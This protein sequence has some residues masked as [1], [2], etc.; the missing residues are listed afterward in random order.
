MRDTSSWTVT[1]HNG[2]PYLEIE[3]SDRYPN[4]NWAPTA[5]LNFG[6]DW[7]DFPATIRKVRE[8]QLPD[9]FE[10]GGF[11]VGSDSITLGNGKI[12]RVS[13]KSA[14]GIGL[15]GYY[16]YITTPN[17]LSSIDELN[18]YPQLKQ[19]T[20]ISLSTYGN[21]SA[22]LF[23]IN[24]YDNK[25]TRVTYSDG[26]GWQS[27][28]NYT[29]SPIFNNPGTAIASISDEEGFVLSY[30]PVNSQVTLYHFKSAIW[31]QVV[32]PQRIKQHYFNCHWFDA[33]ALN[34]IDRLVVFNVNGMSYAMNV[35]VYGVM[36]SPWKIF[37]FDPEFGGAQVRICKLTK[38]NGR[39]IGT[40]WVRFSNS[41]NEYDVSYYQLV[42]TDDGI[43][44]SIPEEGFIGRNPV[45]GKVH[46]I[47]ST[48]AVLGATI[49]YTGKAVQWLGGNVGIITSIANNVINVSLAQDMDKASDAKISLLIP[50]DFNKDLLEY[51]NRVVIREGVVGQASK[52]DLSHLTLDT[53]G[54]KLDN[55]SQSIDAIARG[56]VKKLI[57]YTVPMDMTIEGPIN[58]YNDFTSGG[59]YARTGVW[60]SDTV[61]YCASHNGDWALGTIGLQYSG[62]FQ[63]NTSIRI[64]ES[65]SGSSG[66]I[67]FWYEGLLDYWIIDFINDS[68]ILKQVIGGTEVPITTS[69]ALGN[70]QANQWYDIIIRYI[71]GVLYVYVKTGDSPWELVISQSS[72]PSEEP[73]KW[74]TGLRCKLPST[75]ITESLSI[76]ET[77]IINVQDASNFP[78]SGNI[79]VSQE[80]IFYNSRSAAS[81]GSGNHGSLIRGIR[82]NRSAHPINSTVRIDKQRFESRYFNV[83]QDDRPFSVADACSYVSAITG[84][85]ASAREIELDSASGVRIF[86]ELYGHGWVVSGVYETLLDLYF[87]TNINLNSSEGLPTSGFKLSATSDLIS[88]SDVVSGDISTQIINIPSSGKFKIKTD[89]NGIFLWINGKFVCGVDLPYKSD[90]R[91]GYMGAG[92]SV[93]L[94]ATEMFEPIESIVWAMQESSRDVLS[95]ILTSRDAYLREKND[96]TIEITHFDRRDNLG[97]L[98]GQYFT[99][100]GQ[101]NADQDW[102]SAMVAWGGEDWVL[103]LHPDANRIRWVQW[104]TPHIY[105]KSM[106]RNR[107]MKKLYK[108][109][110]LKDL[111]SIE[112]PFDPRMEVG[113]EVSISSIR[114]IP[115]GLYMIKSIEIRGT[116]KFLNAKVTLTTIPGELSMA[117]WPITPGIDRPI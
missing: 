72:W 49:S 87:W 102:A 104:Q 116:N 51:G 9:T 103:L 13:S 44:W 61:G 14:L 5:N 40:A 15:G 42:W 3:L 48:A 11:P 98:A 71:S 81:F 88:L 55:K 73:L 1:P 86:S 4:F 18:L 21:D 79:A 23:Y 99:S 92:P 115:D 100:Y 47:G 108:L 106:L 70:F 56:P 82:S 91:V 36:S 90:F 32:L 78:N 113:D 94:N 16:K 46:T 33:E 43:N 41:V 65:V 34:Q 62:Q 6:E 59:I 30:N 109:W 25:L 52:V 105:D 114:G 45:R 63:I 26:S 58:H 2:N 89:N 8:R 107:A 10:Y 31:R 20:S 112:G 12:L 50:D 117:T 85:K 67:V 29:N 66:G 111:R 110:A 83:F 19:T 93:V 7:G 74:Y 27:P 75:I 54:I 53:P 39:I 68:I 77:R 17:D 95:R 28:A 96:G 101:A 22:I 24:D 64:T 57:S 69:T 80:A 76:D 60:S 84:I 37:A 38:I 97:T 35:N